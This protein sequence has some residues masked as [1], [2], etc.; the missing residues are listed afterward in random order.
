MLHS[1][2]IDKDAASRY[3]PD[4]GWAYDMKLLGRNYRMTDIQ[5]A[6]GISQLKKLD[7]FIQERNKIASQYNQ[8][9][10]EYDLI[11]TPHTEKEI[12][13]GW[14]IYTVL[15]NETINRNQFFKS[16][17]KMNI[18]V[19]LHYIPVYRHSYYTENFNF[20]KSDYPVTEDV[21]KRIITLPIFPA[22]TT[23]NVNYVVS[24]ISNL[25]DHQ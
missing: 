14:H 17:R 19:N 18:G 8:L 13:H 16:M 21:F 5:A 10:E 4:A 6:L 24:T 11:S 22:M 3:G 15:L 7:Y 9:F 20:D 1:H 23:E 25:I 12:T 2:G